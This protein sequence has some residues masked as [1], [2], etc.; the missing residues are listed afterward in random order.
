[1]LQCKIFILLLAILPCG[2][3][4]GLKAQAHAQAAMRTHMQAV[5]THQQMARQ[6]QHMN[7]M[8]MDGSRVKK[9]EGKYKFNIV[10][11]SGDTIINK[12]KTTV[13]FSKPIKE[14]TI[15]NKKVTSIYTPDQTKEIY[16][17]RAGR[18]ING[19]THEDYWIFNMHSTKNLKLYAPF[20][21]E[22]ITYAA[23]Y[24][25]NGDSIKMITEKFVKELITGNAKAEKAFNKNKILKA[26]EIYIK[27]E[28]KKK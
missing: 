16:F 3:N 23:L 1:M 8:R 9:H 2:I 15:K 27:E 11:L 7:L 5:R 24:Q 6:F 4:S 18:I 21:E 20:P 19:I 26:L 17:K 10:T 12:K 13:L 22:D 25:F 14:I 28:N